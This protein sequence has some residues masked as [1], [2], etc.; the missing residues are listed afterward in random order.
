MIPFVD[1]KA[2]YKTIKLEIDAAV[3]RVIENTSFIGGEE[4]KLFEAEFAQH[5]GS[6]NCV[7]CANGTDSLEILLLAM[8][9]NPGDE[10]IVPAI[11][12]ISTS[13]AVSSIG[14]TPVFVDVE[15][16]HLTIDVTQIEAK[17]TD[18][19][20]AIIPVHL[21]GH[22]C[23]MT[24]VMRIAQKH[25]LYVL[26]DCAQA[27]DA[28]WNG[29]KVGTIG[30]AGSFSFYPGKNLGAYGD[31]GGMIT[32][33]QEIANKARMIAN[34]GQ[35]K[36]HVHRIEGRNS[37]MD[38]MQAAILRVKLPHLD[39]WTGGRITVAK[40]YDATIS[41]SLIKLPAV[42]KNAKH[43]FHLYVIR[44]E[45]RNELAAYLKEKDIQV[46]IHYPTA[47]PFLECYKWFNYSPEDFPIA[48]QNQ[49]KI[50]SIPMYP[51]L[52]NEMVD[53]VSNS[54]SKF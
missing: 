40:Q 43:V 46:A 51:E 6:K 8:G 49:S 30:T 36:K 7:A 18:K 19:T 50:L 28:E 37:R 3:E 22:P 44:S 53:E 4:V 9:V 24:E 1:L 54:L 13:E 29:Q 21:Y 32:D 26:E 27:H 38:G 11:S 25:S 23:N 17:I 42:N 15:E 45:R 10:V 35:V 31:A 52:T 48:Y 34:H 2:Q 12:W 39:K 41:N 20:S 33:D 5:M 14:A 16:E 47:L